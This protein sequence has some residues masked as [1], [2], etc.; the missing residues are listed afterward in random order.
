MK[1][2]RIEELK[3]SEGRLLP[4][5][6]GDLKVDHGG[7]HCFEP[8]EVAHPE[9]RHV[10]NAPEV[11][12]FVQGRGVLPIDGVEHP[13]RTGDVFIIEPGED[14]HTAGSEEDPLVAVWYL[15]ERAETAP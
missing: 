5:R 3:P 15:M 7:V 13:V 14:H 2:L 9:P 11:F 1:K 4:A 12:I 10:H 8:G 6:L